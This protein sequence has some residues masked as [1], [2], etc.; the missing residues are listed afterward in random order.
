MNIA[1]FA[2]RQKVWFVVADTSPLGGGD[3]EV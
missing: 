3:I 2:I 1:R